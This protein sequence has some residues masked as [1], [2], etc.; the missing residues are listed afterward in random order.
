VLLDV[1]G[2]VVVLDEKPV[3]LGVE[4]VGGVFEKK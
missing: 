1:I 4:I 3:V 2:E